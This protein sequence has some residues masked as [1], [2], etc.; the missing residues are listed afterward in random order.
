M[1]IMANPKAAAILQNSMKDALDI[2]QSKKD[3]DED[4][5]AQEA[6]SNEMSLAMMRYMPLRGMISFGGVTHE[7]LK[8]ML[9]AMNS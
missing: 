3:E 2:F 6:V 8:A 9:D 5:A 4:S 7:Q 1:D